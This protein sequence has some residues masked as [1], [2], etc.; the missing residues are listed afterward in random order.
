MGT[1]A[2][3]G[4]SAG[5]IIQLHHVFFGHVLLRMFL[6]S[7]IQRRLRPQAYVSIR[8]FKQIVNVDPAYNIFASCPSQTVLVTLQMKINQ[9]QQAAALMKL[10]QIKRFNHHQINS[11]E[12]LFCA[13]WIKVLHLYY[14]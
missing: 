9:F 2:S 12:S 7:F 10:K 6:N 8:V 14:F 1:S 11:N 4:T 3:Y 13:I 5:D